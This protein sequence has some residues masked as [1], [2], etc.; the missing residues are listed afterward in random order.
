MSKNQNPPS[1]VTMLLMLVNMLRVCDQRSFGKYRISHIIRLNFFPEKCLL[2]L[3][4]HLVF[5]FLTRQPP[6]GQG[7][8]IHVVS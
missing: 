4:L 8:L 1:L 2:K 6:V 5:L 7:L 3:T